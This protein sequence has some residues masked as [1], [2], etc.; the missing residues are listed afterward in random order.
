MAPHRRRRTPRPFAVRT[1][2]TTAV[3]IF[4]GMLAGMLVGLLPYFIA[5]SRENPRLGRTAML[6]C[7]IAG[8][9]MGILL[10]APVA[11]GFAVWAWPRRS[12]R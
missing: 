5:K 9:L 8:A 2:G 11:I 7:T 4:G 3:R 1:L 6:S 12:G 10:A